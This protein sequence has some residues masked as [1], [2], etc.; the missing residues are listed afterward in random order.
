MR[1][2]EAPIKAQKLD[3]VYKAEQHFVAAKA[4]LRQIK[5]AAE[6][7]LNTLP[8][9]PAATQPTSRA[10]AN[11]KKKSSDKIPGDV[12]QA[13][14][15]LTSNN[16]LN[17]REA[18]L[19]VSAPNKAWKGQ[20]GKTYGFGSGG[21]ADIA[22][23]M[24]SLGNFTL[25]GVRNDASKVTAAA[26]DSIGLAVKLVAAAYGVPTGSIGQSASGSASSDTTS[27]ADDALTKADTS[28]QSAEIAVTQ[29]RAAA[30]QILG[31][32][33]QGTP[34]LEDT[35]PPTNHRT[36]PAS[37]PSMT[38]QRIQLNPPP[39]PLTKEHWSTCLQHRNSTWVTAL[40]PCGIS[41]MVRKPFHRELCATVSGVHL[42]ATKSGTSSRTMEIY[43]RSARNPKKDFRRRMSK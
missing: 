21:N 33:V 37:K 28:R 27:A 3:N 43:S 42:M 34:S 14:D 32:I 24:Q 13:F 11:N 7:E 12:Q 36:S 6:A 35:K 9:P 29:Q 5:P 17:D 38:P 23:T 30:L 19:I 26:F 4:V 16:L 2:R 25:K 15:G 1:P 20:F 39:P 41:H 40:I 18:S 8:M 22:I 31:A 10:M